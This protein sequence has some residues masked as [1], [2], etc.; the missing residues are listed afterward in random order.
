M[1]EYK[2]LSKTHMGDKK[3]RPRKHSLRAKKL[4]S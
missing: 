4:N 1:N 3:I 2:K